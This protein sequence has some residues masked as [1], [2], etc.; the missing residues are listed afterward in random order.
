MNI[1]ADELVTF[2]ALYVG[3]R[4]TVWVSDWDGQ[5][6][7]LERAEFGEEYGH[8]VAYITG[9]SSLGQTVTLWAPLSERVSVAL[10]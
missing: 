8:T 4:V 10:R 3:R 2:G 7:T 6:V 5:T 9:A 1:S